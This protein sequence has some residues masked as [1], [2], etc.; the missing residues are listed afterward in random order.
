[1]PHHPICCYPFDN[2]FI[3]AHVQAI[4]PVYEE[5]TRYGKPRLLFS[6]HGLPQHI[7][8]KGDPYP[9][10]VSRTVS[11]I[12]RKFTAAD[13][14]I[15]YQSRVGPRQWI[16]PWTDEE[17]LRAGKDEVPVVVVPVSFVSEHAETLVELDIEYRALAKKNGV[18]YYARVPALGT[19]AAFIE[20]LS[21]LCEATVFY[22]NCSNSLGRQC[23]EES[24][25]CG[26]RE[27]SSQ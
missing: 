6:A 18:P 20:A 17:I 4:R 19:S 5:A 22:P 14:V 10:Q 27:W 7:V 3:D 26:F 2:H 23:P 24:A 8:D 16:K 13:H 12:M 21:W 9:W 11:A 25:K 1:M 15:C